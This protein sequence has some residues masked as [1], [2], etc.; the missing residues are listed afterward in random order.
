MADGYQ[1]VPRAAIRTKARAA[2]YRGD[3]RTSHGFNPG[4]SAIFDWLEEYDRCASQVIH[5]A[6]ARTTRVDARQGQR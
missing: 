1:I 5:H 6:I 2:F 3:S 4:A